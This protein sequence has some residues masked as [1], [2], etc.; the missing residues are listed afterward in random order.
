MSCCDKKGIKRIA[1]KAAN[2]VKGNVR[3]LTGRKYEFTDGRIRICQ[4]C[5][6]NYWIGRSLWCSICKCFIPAKAR[7]EAEECPKGL[8]PERKSPQNENIS[9][10]AEK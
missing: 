10:P 9:L 2:I 8:W 1:H 6:D 7:V 4:R 3:V 5:P